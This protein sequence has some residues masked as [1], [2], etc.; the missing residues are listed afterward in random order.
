MYTLHIYITVHGA[1]HIITNKREYIQ[2]VNTSKFFLSELEEQKSR[3]YCLKSTKALMK[4]QPFW[5]HPFVVFPEE[6]VVFPTKR[7]SKI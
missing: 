5:D 6:V 1:L 7:I 2:I 4:L 3:I